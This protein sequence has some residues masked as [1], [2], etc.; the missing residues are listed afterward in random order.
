MRVSRLGGWISVMSPH[1]KRERS[2]SS[3]VVISLGERSLVRTICF[4]RS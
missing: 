4:F 3:S 1:S 2:R